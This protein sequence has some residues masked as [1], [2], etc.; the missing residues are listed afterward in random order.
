MDEA[1]APS[2]RQEVARELLSQTPNSSSRA[3][4]ELVPRPHGEAC[5]R[6]PPPPRL[7]TWLLRQAGAAAVVVAMGNP[8]GPPRVGT[9]RAGLEVY[10][11]S[12]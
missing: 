5:R 1:A 4:Q 9:P 11:L 2:R 8:G 7:H 12:G 3:G 10:S 6:A